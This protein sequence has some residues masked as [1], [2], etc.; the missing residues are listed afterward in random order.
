[1]H[2]HMLYT[3]RIREQGSKNIGRVSRNK[4]AEDLEVDTGIFDGRVCER[5]CYT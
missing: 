2:Y 3:I 5:R 4:S 1:M